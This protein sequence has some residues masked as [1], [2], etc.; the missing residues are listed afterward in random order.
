MVLCAGA[1]ADIPAVR[2]VAGG[3]ADASSGALILAATDNPDHLGAL[4]APVRGKPLFARRASGLLPAGLDMETA[5][6]AGVSQG[7]LA[8]TLAAAHLDMAR[9]QG[10]WAYIEQRPD[11]YN[12]TS[13]D[14]SY[15]AVLRAGMRPIIQLLVSPGWAVSYRGAQLDD[16]CDGEFCVQPPAPAQYPRFA[17]FAG[18]VARRYPLAG[19]IEV[20][21]E[22]NLWTFWHAGD[23]N[24]GAYA[25]L[26]ATAYD[27]IKASNPA[28]R[29]LGGA[30]SNV[31]ATRQ[32]TPAEC[33]DR[34]AQGAAV[35]DDCR[36]KYDHGYD[37]YLR[38]ILK[39]GAASKMDGLSMHPYPETRDEVGLTRTLGDTLQILSAAGA[40]SMRLVPSE[41]GLRTPSTDWPSDQAQADGT[42]AVYDGLSGA[43]TKITVPAASQVDAVLFF[44]SVEVGRGYG[45]LTQNS[46]GALT[47]RPVYCLIADRLGSRPA[48]CPG[49]ELFADPV[50]APATKKPKAKKKKKTV[51]KKATKKS[52]AHAPHDVATRHTRP[53]VY[54]LGRR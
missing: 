25:A 21:N 52:S 45:W 42:L 23:V 28:M 15:L 53:I 35:Y 31:Y 29:V 1:Q 33:A 37:E 20:W 12:F 22:P 4:T 7:P 51:K 13:L 17:R 38:D 41:L 18:A 50:V 43:D 39:D 24:A 5:E 27:A 48:Q 10:T 49:K 2:V 19:A 9:I 30:L 36:K 8:Q 34:F 3:P 11:E 47:P 44:E 54:S 16:G 40:S 14:A 26:L 6:G 32:P 46:T